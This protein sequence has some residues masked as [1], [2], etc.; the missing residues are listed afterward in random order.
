MGKKLLR[1]HG[2]LRVKLVVRSGKQ[3]VATKS[4]V[5]RRPAKKHRG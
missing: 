5:L 3:L 2:K 4:L 1:A